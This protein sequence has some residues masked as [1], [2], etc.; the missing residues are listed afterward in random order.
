MSDQLPVTKIELPAEFVKLAGEI[1]INLSFAETIAKNYIPHLQEITTLTDSLRSLDKN[2]KEDAAKAKRIALDLGS[3]CAR[4]EETKKKDKASYLL[5]TRYIDGL[6][7]T[8]TGAARLTQAEAKTI[9]EYLENQKALE[10]QKLRETRLELIKAHDPAYETYTVELMTQE[11]FDKFAFDLKAKF[12]FQAK[13]AA[14]KAASKPAEP[15]QPLFDAQGNPSS[16]TPSQ[17]NATAMQNP[18]TPNASF[19]APK[20]M[21]VFTVS[22][23][24]PPSSNTTPAAVVM[25]RTREEIEAALAKFENALTETRKVIADPSALEENKK[26][27]SQQQ[28]ILMIKITTLE[29]VLNKA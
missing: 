6:F 21:P 18:V 16:P 17:V 26:L 2:K 4:V 10:L 27:A 5:V 28:G 24:G 23:S 19:L 14:M 12:D 7:N 3:L 29:W 13:I 1:K 25:M 8:V 20:P 22:P 9:A 15:V 11:A